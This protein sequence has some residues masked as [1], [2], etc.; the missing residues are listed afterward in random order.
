MNENVQKTNHGLIEESGKRGYSLIV[1]VYNGKKTLPDTLRSLFLLKYDQYEVIVVD[2]ASTDETPEIARKAGAK[3][4]SLESNSGPATARNRGAQEAVYDRLLFTDSDVLLPH[5]LLTQLDEQFARSKTDAVQG[6]FSEV[7]PFANYF[8]QYKNLYNRYVLNQLPEWIDTTFTSVTAVK[9][10]AFLKCGGFDENIRT[11][12]IEDRTL[13]RHLFQYGFR[14]YFDRR[15]EVIHNKKLT[16]SG[17]VRNQFRRSR[18]LATFMLRCRSEK[19][20]TEEKPTTSPVDESGRFGTNAPSTM[21]RIPVV[22]AMITFALIAC[23]SPVLFLALIP[24]FLSFLYLI[25]PFEWY[26]TK[27]RGPSFAVKGIVVNFLD[28][29]VSGLGVLFGIFDFFLCGK[30]Y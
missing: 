29:C 5:S 9:R 15:L 25:L 7:C 27:K 17:F 21:L 4:I 13:G 19:G 10:K 3:V 22:Y 11:A 2:D 26:L 16:F 6:T 8:S 28:A 20:D 14:I 12:S 1:P 18:D 30:K 23:F 24:L